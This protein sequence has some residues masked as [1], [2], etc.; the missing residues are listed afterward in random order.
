VAVAVSLATLGSLAIAGNAS[1]VSA[2]NL[3]VANA[4]AGSVAWFPSPANTSP[5]TTIGSVTNAGRV[6]ITPDGA[7]AYVVE[8]GNL[9]GNVARIDTST[10]AVVGSLIPVGQNPESIAIPAAPTPPAPPSSGPSGPTGQRAAALKKC[11]KKKSATARKK[12]KKN[13]NKLPV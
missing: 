10:N 13:A 5:A 7:T 11:K 4:F 1:A 6:A 9:G 3:Y 2:R 12:C 8:V